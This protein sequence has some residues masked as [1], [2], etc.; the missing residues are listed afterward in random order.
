MYSSLLGAVGAAVDNDEDSQQMVF[1][2][3]FPAYPVDNAAVPDCP[4]SRRPGCILGINH[5]IYFTGG[6]ACPGTLRSATVGIMLLSMFLL[7]LAMFGAIWIAAKIY[8][9]GLLMYGKKVNLIE[10]IKW[11]RYKS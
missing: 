4:Q 9:T 11:L 3:T 10:L 2:I 1:P 7:L 5:S 6:N 8:K